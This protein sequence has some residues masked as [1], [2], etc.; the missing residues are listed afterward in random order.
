MSGIFPDEVTGGVIV[1]DDLGNPTNPSNVQNAYIPAQAFL[2]SCEMT[3]IPSDCTGRITPAQINAIVSEL[4]AFAECMDP[5]GPWNCASLTNLRAAF[6]AW[7]AAHGG[8]VSGEDPPPSPPANPFWFQSD[9]GLLFYFYDGAWVQI[10]GVVAD[11]LT[12]VGMG[13]PGDPLRVG[14]IDCGVF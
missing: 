9:T 2:M 12:I 7:V 13:L 6:T 11:N 4:V 1:R 14:A 8:V 5:D 3:A 10:G